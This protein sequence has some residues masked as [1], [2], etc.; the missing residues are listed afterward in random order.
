MA[1]VKN[2][3]LN[4]GFTF[5]GRKLFIFYGKKGFSTEIDIIV[6]VLNDVRP[7]IFD[8]FLNEEVMNVT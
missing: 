6:F 7:S 2:N 1:F 5:K 8:E 4:Y 3:N